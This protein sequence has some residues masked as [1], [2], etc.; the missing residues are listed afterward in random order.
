MRASNL[1]IHIGTPKT[2]TTSLQTFCQ[3]NP[4]LL[5]DHGFAYFREPENHYSACKVIK[6]LNAGHDMTKYTRRFRR[7]CREQEV[8]NILISSESLFHTNFARLTEFLRPQRWK[9]IVV[10][11]YLRPQEELLEGVYKQFVKWGV[12]LKVSDMLTPRYSHF[13]RYDARLTAWKQWVDQY[14]GAELIVRRYG[15]EHLVDGNIGI[16][17]FAQLGM[18]GDAFQIPP[19]NVSPSRI[20]L[21]MYTLLSGIERLQ[22][23][24]RKVV[25]SGAPGVCGRN[26]IF[27][28][29]QRQAIRSGFARGNETVRQ[30][31]FPD[32]EVLF[33]APRPMS[34]AVGN[35]DEIRDVLLKVISELRGEEVASRAR[36]ELS[37]AA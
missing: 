15:R 2:G 22:Q 21:E 14:D 27:D 26:D 34:P 17:L 13:G 36:A 12:P 31:F 20:L 29:A 11:C 8:D 33:P 24:N 1:Y 4:D 16:D 23:I 5:K 28:D 25:A 32:D 18:T 6:A 37:A 35:Y 9:K 30:M 3:M 10:L 19:L 7:W